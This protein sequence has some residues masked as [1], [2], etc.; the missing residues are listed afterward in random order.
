MTNPKLVSNEK[1]KKEPSGNTLFFLVRNI[2]KTINLMVVTISTLQLC[3]GLLSNNGNY[4]KQEKE[5]HKDYLQT[6]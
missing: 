3:Y 6:T 4:M 1:R 5:K 2:T